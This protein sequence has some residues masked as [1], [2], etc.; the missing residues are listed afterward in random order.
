MVCSQFG[1]SGLYVSQMAFGTWELEKTAEVEMEPLINAALDA[2]INLIDTAPGYGKGRSEGIVGNVVRGRGERERV[3]IATKCSVPTPREPNGFMTTRRSIIQHCEESLRRLGT[4]YIDLYQLHCVERFVPVD[5]TLA[6]LT[7]L[8]ESGKIRY[9]GMSNY[10]G[11][12]MV[13]ACWASEKHHYT[14]FVSDQSEYHLFD[15]LAERENFPAM[16]SYGLAAMA[17]SPL[18]R[19]LLACGMYRGEGAAP[20]EERERQYAANP[21]NL[22]FGASLQTAM[23]KL[24]ALSASCGFTPSALAL[25]FVMSHPIAPV[26]IIAPRDAAQLRDCLSACDIE[27]DDAMRKAFDGIVAPGDKL[28]GQRFNAYNHGPTARWF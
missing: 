18:K 15:R 5:E 22:Y 7:T 25:A 3:L 24:V 10:K 28:F 21:S 1:R 12:Q 2:G 26:P 13:E 27:V 9:A 16:Q 14:K 11:W 17:Y 6:A 23:G 20:D 19:G 4:D 8:V